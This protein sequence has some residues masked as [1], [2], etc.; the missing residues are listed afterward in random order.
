VTLAEFM[1]TDEFLSL[2]SRE[3]VEVLQEIAARALGL[4]GSLFRGANDLDTSGPAEFADNQVPE[5]IRDA[6]K[7]IAAFD[8]CACG[9]VRFGFGV[10]P[11][12]GPATEAR[13]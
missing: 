4:E 2:N 11:V 6:P 13:R 10:C 5:P 1:A 3:R 7:H 8:I 9:A 12:C